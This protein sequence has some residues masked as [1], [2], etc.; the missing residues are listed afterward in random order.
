MA[1]SLRYSISLEYSKHRDRGFQRRISNSTLAFAIF[2][3]ISIGQIQYQDFGFQRQISISKH[4]IH[5]KKYLS[6]SSNT[7]LNFH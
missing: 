2:Y 4:R 3:S 7:L 5:I 6:D 1:L